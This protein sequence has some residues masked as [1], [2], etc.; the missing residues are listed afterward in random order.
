[1]FYGGRIDVKKTNLTDLPDN[2]T[3]RHITTAYSYG[4]VIH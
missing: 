4:N 1:M 3:P 2:L